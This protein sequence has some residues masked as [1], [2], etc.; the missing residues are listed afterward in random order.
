MI[1]FRQFPLPK[2]IS[3]VS[4]NERD[5]GFYGFSRENDE[6]FCR[7]QLFQSLR[8]GQVRMKFMESL[9]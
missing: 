2:Q 1:R 9:K 4:L 7:I 5:S 3:H 6:S 8:R